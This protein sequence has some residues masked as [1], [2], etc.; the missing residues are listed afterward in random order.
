MDIG[1]NPRHVA[2]AER[3]VA[4]EEGGSIAGRGIRRT[5]ILATVCKRMG[6]SGLAPI[7]LDHRRV[8]GRLALILRHSP[9]ALA[10]VTSVVIHRGTLT[11]TL[12]AGAWLCALRTRDEDVLHWEPPRY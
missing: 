6:M 2:S 7:W 10:V 5:V 1:D 3:D 4:G 11:Q 8:S 12:Q 9:D